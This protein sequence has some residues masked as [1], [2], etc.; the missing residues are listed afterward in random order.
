M[1]GPP[2]PYGRTDHSLLVSTAA[3]PASSISACCNGGASQHVGATRILYCHRWA[4]GGGHEIADALNGGMR[5]SP[6]IDK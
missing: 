4:S 1:K 2:D 5:I 3:A 6:K